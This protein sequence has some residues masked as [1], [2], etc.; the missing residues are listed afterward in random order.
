MDYNLHKSNS[1]Y[2]T[3]LDI[4]RMHLVVCIMRRGLHKVH[5]KT[6]K[7]LMGEN[8]KGRFNIVFGGV[9]CSFRREIRPGQ[10]YE[11]WTRILA[12]DNKWLYLVSH[13]VKKGA[14]KPRGYTLQPWKK[15]AKKSE[16][17][18]ENVSANGHV[19]K[20]PAH[21]AILATSVSK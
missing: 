9:Q 1:T 20:N 18:D 5:Y 7:P 8:T 17:K 14:V 11:V 2:F 10:S 13:I 19:N 6:A 15:G 4:S 12:W 21:P 16:K 3:D